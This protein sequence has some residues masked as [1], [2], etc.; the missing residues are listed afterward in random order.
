MQ[1]LLIINQSSAHA[2]VQE[3]LGEKKTGNRWKG[4]TGREIHDVSNEHTVYIAG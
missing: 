2:E 1:W 4:E 3:L